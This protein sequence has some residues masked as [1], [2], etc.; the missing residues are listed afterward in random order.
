VTSVAAPALALASALFCLLLILLVPF[1]IAGLCLMNTGLGR[2]RSASHAMA[3]SLLVTSVAVIVYFVCGFAWQGFTG[4][5]AHIVTVAGKPWN[6][7]AATPFFFRGLRFNGSSASLAAS[8]EMLSVALAAVIPLGSG[9]DRWRLSASCLSTVLLAGWTY[10][11][12]AHWVWGAGWLAQLGTN[13]GL[14][15]GFVDAGGDGSIQ[16]VGGLTALAIAWLLGP[17]RGKYAPDGTLTALPGHNAV[18][19]L[20]G[21]LL[22]LLGWVGLNSAGAILFTSAQP[23]QVVLVAIN[24]TLCA[25][26][27]ALSAAAI[28]GARF[29]KPD[30]SLTGNGWVGGLVA[31]SAAC[32]FVTPAAAVA[33]GFVAGLFVT[34]AVEWFEV[35]VG[36]DDPGGAISVHAVCGIWGLLAVAIFARFPTDVVGVA[37]GGRLNSSTGQWL[38]QLVGI[39]TL[40]GFVL[41]LTYG[42]NWLLN[43]F[44]PQ[45]VAVEGERQGMDLYELGAGAY[46]EFVT[47]S[48]DFTM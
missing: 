32:V 20:F 22:A 29:G 1:A 41:P 9:A 14:G 5:P 2:S 24:T 4:E 47:H 19:V 23:G 6:W 10:P 35:R 28:T 33:T 30:A 25:A 43:R 39:A 38:A 37:A 34:F 16:M 31:S 15:H 17:R 13:F 26:T 27:A 11:L 45:R 40:I 3:T 48:E 21:G 42:L 46:P 18:Y 12:F 44:F 8:L 36:V 7:I